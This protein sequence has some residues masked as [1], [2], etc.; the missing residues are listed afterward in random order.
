[1]KDRQMSKL[2]TYVIT[3]SETFPKGHIHEGLN[4]DFKSK[5]LSGSKKH[6]IRGNYPFWKKRIDNIN[7]GKAI[8]SVRQWSGKPYNS[9]QVILQELTKVG[10]QKCEIISCKDRVDIFIDGRIQIYSIES[11]II[12]ND[13][14]TR[15]DFISWFYTHLVNGCI[16][17]FTDLKYE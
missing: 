14:L 7:A 16:L 13:G 11:K 9:K 6:T 17:H 8:L 10:I 5:F 15:T 4:T 12:N 3:L 1:M 2:K